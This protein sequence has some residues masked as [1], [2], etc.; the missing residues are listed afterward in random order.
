[1]PAIAALGFPMGAHL[2]R[3][4]HNTARVKRNAHGRGNVNEVHGKNVTQEDLD[5]VG[6][7]IAGAPETIGLFAID[8]ATSRDIAINPDDYFP[9]AS[10]LK[11]PL[12]YTFIQACEAGDI[13]PSER[14]TLRHADRV[15]GSGVLQDLDE[16]LQPTWR[17][18]A[19]LM[20]TVS[21]NYATDLLFAKLGKE[22]IAATCAAL[23]MTRTALPLTIKQLFCAGVHL[24]ANDPSLTYD[25]LRDALENSTAD[26]EN[27]AYADDP[28]NDVS[29]PRDLVRC[30]RAIEDADRLSAASRQGAIDIPLHQKYSTI[31]P[32]WLPDE[33][34]IAHKTGSLKGIR[35]D[36]GIVYAPAGPY[37][38]AIMS[39]RSP[40]TAATVQRLA[41]LSKAVW[42]VFAGE[43]ASAA[44]GAVVAHAETP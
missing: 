8:P 4:R 33:V 35:N 37:V 38:I 15:P 1:M 23:G 42:D 36:A 10:T 41:R 31:L 9:A 7:V 12:L 16:G 5:A 18:V 32:F 3:A 34:K 44:G 28:R 30:L 21:D 24:D 14:T 22:R 29:S 17:D 40:D 20:I 2:A 26:P 13:D 39:K 11:V 19:E 27:V 25:A 6:A 43:G